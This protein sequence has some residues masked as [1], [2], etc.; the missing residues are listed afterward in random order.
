MNIT[1]KLRFLIDSFSRKRNIFRI[2]IGVRPLQKKSSVIGVFAWAVKAATTYAMI[3]AP[4]SIG[5]H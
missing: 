2:Q 4:W 3:Y 5:A 1:S